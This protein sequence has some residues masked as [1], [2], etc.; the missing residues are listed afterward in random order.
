MCPAANNCE[1]EALRCCKDVSSDPEWCHTGLAGT[2]CSP[3]ECDRPCQ[4]NMGTIHSY[5]TCMREAEDNNPGNPVQ[6]HHDETVCK[7]THMQMCKVF[8]PDANLMDCECG[9]RG[10]NPYGENCYCNA[11]SAECGDGLYCCDD[12]ECTFDNRLFF[13][14]CVAHKP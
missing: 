12:S 13:R 2:S 3:S 6:R 10:M 11:Q 5:K 9:A 14:K 4:V 8:T 1:I 7:D